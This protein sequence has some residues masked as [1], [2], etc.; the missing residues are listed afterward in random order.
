MG[1]LGM[2]V[3]HTTILREIKRSARAGAAPAHVK[4][5]GVDDW[6]WKKGANYGNKSKVWRSP[7]VETRM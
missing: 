7:S 4:V 1:R 2:R 3:D 5:V 6:A